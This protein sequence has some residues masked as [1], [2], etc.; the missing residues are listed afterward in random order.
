MDGA[1]LW[2]A[3]AAL[4]RPFREFTVDAGVDILSL[5][6]TKNGLLGAE[7]VVV[8]APQRATGLVY[9]RKLTMQLASKMRFAAVV[10]ISRPSSAGE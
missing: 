2:N 4:G 9:L 10:L 7:A 6:G 1:R 8:L 5:G 3:A